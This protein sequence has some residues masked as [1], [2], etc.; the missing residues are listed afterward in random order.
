MFARIFTG[1]AFLIASCSGAAASF[2]FGAL[3]DTPYTQFEE[4]HF[5]ALVAEMNEEALAFVVHVGDFRGGNLHCSDALYLQR[6]AWFESVRHP[7]VYV[8]GDNE[9]R[10]CGS[11]RAGRYDPLERL[12][13]LR[14]LSFGA[15]RVTANV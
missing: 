3:G 1:L 6:K 12:A 9:W 11:P 7:F 14:G 5:P 15:A 10:D 2:T 13:K 4:A 8:P